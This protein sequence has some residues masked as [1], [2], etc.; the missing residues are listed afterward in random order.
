MRSR[1]PLAGPSRRTFL[2][3][4]ALGGLAAVTGVLVARQGRQAC[5]NNGICRGCAAYDE[6]G[7]PQALSAKQAARPPTG[8][9]K[10][11]T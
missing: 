9:V 11:E 4:A 1:T 10:H 6:C 8:E 2:R 3:N 5:V 7:L